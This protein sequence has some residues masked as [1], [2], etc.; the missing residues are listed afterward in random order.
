[1]GRQ[2]DIDIAATGAEAFYPLVAV[3]LDDVIFIKLLRDD[4]TLYKRGFLDIDLYISHVTYHSSRAKQAHHT[5][6]R[7]HF[8]R[9]PGGGNLR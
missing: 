7:A 2:R 9:I 3:E 8:S 4:R 6:I 1:M 5:R